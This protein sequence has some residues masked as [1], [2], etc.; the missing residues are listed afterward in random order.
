M[1]AI[2]CTRYGSPDVLRYEEVQKPGPGDNDV[3]IK[4][5]AA[6]LNA[7]DWH[8]MR[9]S[10]YF[11]RFI[12][13][14]KKPKYQILGADA[15]GVVEEIGKNVTQFKIGDEVFGNLFQEGKAERGFGAFAE[16]A[17]AP[18][19]AFVL[20]PANITFE[21]AAAMPLASVSAFQ[22]LL[23]GEIKEGQKV[24]IDGASGGVGT[25]AVQIAKA[26]NTEVTAVCSTS[27]IPTMRSIGADHVID[28]TKEN[29]TENG[30]RYDLIVAANAFHPITHYKRVLSK[31]G[32]YVGVG[33]SMK[34]MMQG[35]ALGPLLSNSKGKKLSFL[36]ASS[37]HDHLLA[38]RDLAAFGKIKPVIEKV[39]ELREV[40]EAM[41]YLEEGHVKGKLVIRI[42]E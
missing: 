35:M 2:V 8:V 17:C 26:F 30:K 29:F 6:A 7:A 19:K 34:S 15:S 10:P 18:E 5:R 22:A 27:K 13:G 24:L 12:F 42:T 31:S 3:L 38:V 32:A 28:Y 1:K 16:Y 39:Y 41:R 37:N 4:I 14:F 9:G 11:M 23:K 25:Y 20:K 36:A 40:P 33:G 21:E